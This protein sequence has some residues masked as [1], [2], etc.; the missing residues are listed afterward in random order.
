MSAP[1]TSPP[2]VTP[3]QRRRWPWI[4]LTLVLLFL[5]APYSLYLFIS[6]SASR[7]AD[8]LIAETTRRDPT[9]KLEDIEAE[10]EAL[11][12]DQNSALQVIK[13]YQLARNNNFT[14]KPEFYEAFEKF[15]PQYQMNALQVNLL[16]QALE[17]LDE[18]L[19]EAR[20]LKD[21]P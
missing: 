14:A 9:W 7:D 5:G 15:E 13:I 16:D 3:R 17:G 6:W 1:S 18:A 21:M 2:I 11:P 19:V 12:P 4:L 8:A 10:R 20:K